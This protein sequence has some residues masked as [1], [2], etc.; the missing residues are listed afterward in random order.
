MTTINALDNTDLLI[1]VR[2]LRSPEG[3]ALLDQTHNGPLYRDEIDAL[4]ERLESEAD[5]GMPLAAE[6]S[7]EDVAHDAYGLFLWHQFESFRALGPLPAY[8][9]LVADAA[10]LQTTW[11]DGRARLAA[12]YGE[13]AAHAGRLR[14]RLDGDRAGLD[15]LR[16]GR[17]EAL[18]D[19]AER[20]VESG[21]RIGRLLARRADILAERARD[22]A[23]G[24]RNLRGQVIGLLG[25]L[26]AQ[27][28]NESKR[29]PDLPADLDARLFGQLDERIARKARARSGDAPAVEAPAPSSQGG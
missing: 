19:F 29:R 20:F 8:A 24:G 7:A 17:G 4:G 22:R 6:L 15:A 28:A 21:E 13:Q 14:R 10:A 25:E 1:A 18:G 5:G 12:G 27:I 9:D 26:R 3:Q 23:E 11:I 2:R 16:A